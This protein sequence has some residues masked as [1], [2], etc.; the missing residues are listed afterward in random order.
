MADKHLSRNPH[1][2]RG[3]KDV[4]WYDDKG[5]I[6]VMVE[7]MGFNDVTQIRIPWR[8]IRAALY[9]KERAENE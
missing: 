5:G 8:S 1:H 6:D 9:R 4:W 2:L 7:R 3:R